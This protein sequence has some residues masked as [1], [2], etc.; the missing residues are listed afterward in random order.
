MKR[1]FIVGGDGFARECYSYI[2]NN[3]HNGDDICFGGFVGHNGYH[4]NFG[5]LEPFFVGD[6]SNITFEKDDY[7]IIGA[8]FPG[9]RRKI[10]ADL[11]KKGASFYNLIFG[12]GKVNDLVEMGEGNIL[13]DSFPSPFV[14]IGNGNVF[15]YQVI[16]AHDVVIGDF[17]FFGPRCQ[18]LG[19]ISIGNFNTI[20]A[21]AIM[22]P[23]SK[24]GNNNKIAPLSVIYKGCRSNCY[25]QGNPALKS[26]VVEE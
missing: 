4:V 5:P 10:Y 21:N 2:Q 26:G 25:M 7:C 15:N 16:I 17:N 24:V 11:K 12:N 18:L 13:I 14:K 23:H 22:L 3:I 8:G 19:T 6:L 20:G 1:I 9:L